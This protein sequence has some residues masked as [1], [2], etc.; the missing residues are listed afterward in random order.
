[1]TRCRRVA[2]RLC[3]APVTCGRSGQGVCGERCAEPMQTPMPAYS[4]ASTPAVS[5]AGDSPRHYQEIA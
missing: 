5:L 2:H 1:M 3:A 4:D